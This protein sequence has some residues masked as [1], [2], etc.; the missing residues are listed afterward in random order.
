MPQMCA[1]LS[2]SSRTMS[3]TAR[4]L[5]LLKQGSREFGRAARV[6]DISGPTH[7][8]EPVLRHSL[9]TL[10]SAMNWLEDTPHFRR[11]H[12]RLDAAGR[13]ARETFPDGCNLTFENGTYFQECPAALAHTRVGMSIG[14]LVREAACSI[15]SE[16]PE[17]CTHIKGRMYD[18]ERCC[19]IIKR[20]DLLEISLVARP[21]QPDAR[22]ERISIET[23]RLRAGLGDDFRPGIAVTCDRCLSSCKG[24]A[25]PFEETR[26]GIR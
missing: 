18:D 23:S 16:D 10:R 15:C 21:A 24:V 2:V 17:D 25:R 6:I 9:Q 14:Y 8:I 20:L 7:D 12:Q 13:L 22:I 11:A 3:A 1:A 5:E 26:I 4:G 19:R